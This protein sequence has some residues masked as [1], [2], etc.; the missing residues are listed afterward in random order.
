M[1]GM[2]HVSHANKLA[3]VHVA[4]V[5]QSEPGRNRGEARRGVARRSVA[6][7]LFACHNLCRA[8]LCLLLLLIPL[9]REF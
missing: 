3:L 6:V 9:T 7:V 5:G 2:W 1:T 4:R 8:L